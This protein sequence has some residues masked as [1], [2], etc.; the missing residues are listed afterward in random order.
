MI[1][2]NCGFFIKGTCRFA[3][4]KN[5]L[6]NNYKEH[7]I[8][9][10]KYL[11]Y[12]S[13]LKSFKG[14]NE[15][16]FSFWKLNIFNCGFSTKVTCAFLPQKFGGVHSNQTLFKSGM[17]DTIFH[18][19]NQINL[20]IGT[21]VNRTCFKCRDNKIITV[22]LKIFRLPLKSHLLEETLHCSYL[23]NSSKKSN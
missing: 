16:D 4:T 12:N 8:L 6:F 17:Y 20:L 23:S 10:V 22:S 1:I 19:I 5:Y 21:V 2:Y 3:K 18:I 13:T 14:S 11:I 7:F 15:L 9:K